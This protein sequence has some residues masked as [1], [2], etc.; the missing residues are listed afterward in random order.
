MDDLERCDLRTSERCQLFMPQGT[1]DPYTDEDGITT[2]SCFECD[3]DFSEEQREEIR[4]NEACEHARKAGRIEEAEMLHQMIM[5]RM[6][7]RLEVL[8]KEIRRRDA[9]AARRN[10]N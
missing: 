4:L 2:L 3:P 5:A 8:S 1:A 9:E 7:E 6:D 10:L